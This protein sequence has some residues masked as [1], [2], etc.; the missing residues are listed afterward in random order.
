MP[1]Y[2]QIYNDL[3]AMIKSGE[4]AD[5]KLL[6]TELQLAKQYNASRI[7]VKKAYDML[8]ADGLVTRTAGRGTTLC[9]YVQDES[10]KSNRIIGIILC[11]I[12]SAFGDRLLLSAEAAAEKADYNI[13]FKR[14]FGE[15]DAEEKLFS[16]LL[17]FPVDGIIVQNCPGKYTKGFLECICSGYPVI[18]VDRADDRLPVAAVSSDNAAAAENATKH[19]FDLG[20]RGVLCLS[21]PAHEI[22]TLYERTRGFS[23]AYSHCGY[24]LSSAQ[25][26]NDVC[27]FSDGAKAVS[28]QVELIAARLREHPEITA[29]LALERYCA[30][31]AEK[32]V[33]LLGKRIPEDYSLICFDFEE[34][35]GDT[36]SITHVCQNQTEMGRLAV[37]NL[38]A[39]IESGA[40]PEKVE[41][42]SA[43]I[44]GCS[45]GENNGTHQEQKL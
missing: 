1:L 43:L 21:R 28:H 35:Y 20:H 14:S 36:P 42:P 45:T 22:T 11:D 9:D 5:G 12:D 8:V 27:A 7:T 32:A 39:M 25:F 10:K 18:S 19:L 38:I 15:R 23:E 44:T 34:H 33:A 24:P 31:L 41:V 26:M 3:L 4:F 6:P 37:T 29:V 30:S 16:Q 2:R 13:V 17:S 40:A